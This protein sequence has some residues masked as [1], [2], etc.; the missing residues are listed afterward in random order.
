MIFLL[1][2]LFFCGF[3]S[4]GTIKEVTSDPNWINFLQL[5]FPFVELDIKYFDLGLPHRDA[6]D[7]KVTVESAEATLKYDIEFLYVFCSTCSILY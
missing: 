1:E 6:T 7:D 2:L 3:S 5:I 4:E